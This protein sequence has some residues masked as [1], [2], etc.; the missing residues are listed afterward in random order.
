M[1][2]NPDET[3]ENL[4]KHLG[5]FGISGNLALRPMYLLSGG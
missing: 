5:A 1:K 3:A 4:R 2:E